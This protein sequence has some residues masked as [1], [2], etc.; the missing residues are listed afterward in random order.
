MLISE[1]D[2]RA[3]NLLLGAAALAVAVK[4]SPAPRA[5]PP[6][7]RGGGG[8]QRHDLIFHHGCSGARGF[9]GIGLVP[10]TSDALR[11]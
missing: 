7:D 4:S 2:P 11:S 1:V 9:F 5:G 6:E 8:K 3:D 10:I